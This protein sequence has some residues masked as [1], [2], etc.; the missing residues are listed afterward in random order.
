M[1][2]VC[3]YVYAVVLIAPGMILHPF[4]KCICKWWLLRKKIEN[5]IE[6]EIES[7]FYKPL[8][9]CYKCV[10]GQFAFW[11]YLYWAISDNVYHLGHHIF[12]VC[13]SILLSITI[14]KINSI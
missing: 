10:S 4:Y 9:G 5:E 7:W 8:I 11:S 3:A 12:C 2:A 14:N 1:C 13:L 6:V